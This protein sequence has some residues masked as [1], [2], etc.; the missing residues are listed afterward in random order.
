MRWSVVRRSA[1]PSWQR[2]VSGLQILQLSEVDGQPLITTLVSYRDPA[3][4]IRCGLP[5]SL[6]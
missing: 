6:P 5:P 1:W 3:L 2:V 4:A